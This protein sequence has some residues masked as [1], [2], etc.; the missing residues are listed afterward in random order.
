[1]SKKLCVSDLTGRS[2]VENASQRKRRPTPKETQ[3]KFPKLDA[4]KPEVNLSM[5]VVNQPFCGKNA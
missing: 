3:T 4:P 2:C 1:V 5:L